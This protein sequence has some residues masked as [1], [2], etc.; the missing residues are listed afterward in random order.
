MRGGAIGQALHAVSPFQY[1]DNTAL[2][3]AVCDLHELIGYPAEI[4]VLQL[5]R[6]QRVQMMRVESR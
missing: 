6:S 5:K 4:I 3:T 1:R 2:A